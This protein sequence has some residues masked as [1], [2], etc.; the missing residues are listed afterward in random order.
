MRPIY[1]IVGW[2]ILAALICAFAAG[3]FG[4]DTHSARDLRAARA[5]AADA[6]LARIWRGFIIN[7]CVPYSGA[8]CFTGRQ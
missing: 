1:F 3:A 2:I 8:R 5:A 4:A 6:R 7:A